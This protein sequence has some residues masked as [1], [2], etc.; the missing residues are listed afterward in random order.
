[1]ACKCGVTCTASRCDAV[2]RALPT[3]QRRSHALASAAEQL[4]VL[5]A[6]PLPRSFE[7]TIA[8]HG[9]DVL[10]AE[11]TSIL[12]LNLGKRCNQTCRHC[13]VDA[14]PDRREIMSD[15]VLDAALELLAGQT[16]S[17]L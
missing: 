5:E 8:Q 2:A 4:R 10:R 6:V 11:R 15:A 1:M 3:L 9:P 7:D 16:F 12:Q 17:A 14:G 13:H